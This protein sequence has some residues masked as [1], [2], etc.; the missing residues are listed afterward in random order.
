MK[1]YIY[2]YILDAEIQLKTFKIVYHLNYVFIV[3]RYTFRNSSSLKRRIIRNRKY[4]IISICW[5]KYIY[6]VNM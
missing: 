3:F 5:F 2:I 4:R 1:E 6:F